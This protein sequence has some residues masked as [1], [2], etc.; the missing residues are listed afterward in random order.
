MNESLDAG[1][2]SS[3]DNSTPATNSPRGIPRYT[4]VGKIEFDMTKEELDGIRRAIDERG[5][6]MPKKLKIANDAWFNCGPGEATP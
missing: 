3:D 4:V 2:P 6:R 1:G 5:I